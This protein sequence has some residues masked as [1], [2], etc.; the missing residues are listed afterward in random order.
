MKLNRKPSL[1]ESGFAPK[2]ALKKYFGYNNFRLEQEA[3]VEN[4]LN[5]NDTFVLMPTG[6]GKSICY[7]LPAL[8]IEGTAI[9]ISPLIALMKDQVDALKANGV[10]AAYLNSTQSAEE[11]SQILFRLRNGGLKILYLAPEKLLANNGE[12]ISFLKELSLSLVAIDEAHCISQWGH[13]FRPEYLMLYR[14][15]EELSDLPFI[16][17]TATADKLTRTDILDKL[18]LNKPQTYVSSFNRA[19]IEY[20]VKPKQNSFDKLL[21]FLAEQDEE[22]GIIYTLS[23]KET[24]SLA[25]RLNAE[26]YEA[27]PY[28]AGLGR[29]IREQNQD[30]FLKDEVKIIVATIAFGMGIDKSNVRYVVHMTMPKNIEG[31]YQ[32][33]GRAGRD[34]L[35]SKALMFYSN[36]DLFKLKSFAEVEGNEEQSAVMLK[37]LNTMGD[38]CETISCRRKYLL[39]YFG[40]P[41]KADNCNSC[42]V[43]LTGFEMID[44]TTPA[45]MVLS[46]MVRLNSGFGMN[47]I[48]Q[49][50]RGSKSEK[51]WESHKS[52]KTY[53]VGRDYSKDEW[54]YMIR[55]FIQQGCIKKSDGN[56]PVLE[57]TDT[58]KAVL[59]GGEKVLIRK[60]EEKVKEDN[61]T[62]E[63]EELPYEED[64]FTELRKVRK[65]LADQ[66]GVP[67]FVIFS[68]VTLIELCTYLPLAEKDLYHISGFGEVKIDKYGYSFLEEITAYCKIHKLDSRINLKVGT[69]KS[70]RPR[71]KKNRESDTKKASLELHKQGLS[72]K[73]I[74]RERG[75]AVTT[76]EGHLAFYVA[77]GEVGVNNFVIPNKRGRIEEVIGK[78][79]RKALTPIKNELGDDYSYGEIKMVIAHLEYLGSLN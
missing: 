71:K 42:D 38:Y 23:R 17:L 9:V 69:V 27:K 33:T 7:Q 74:S 55:E 19:N 60:P 62:L 13:D 72:I 18:K 8:M 32:E 59:T 48:I 30:L 67:P 39:N 26:G 44:A 11:Q 61:T 54:S 28:H 77:S 47:Y 5:G 4:V 21:D 24:E 34:G 66:Q 45:Q 50:L 75:L 57:F 70:N 10:D 43:C 76:I 22:A 78:V 53:G 46:A 29:E 14:L 79:G 25:A 58:S 31:Y 2:E 41:F 16:A 64:L 68:D 12:F 15:R 65:K 1:S 40:E 6:G 52:L 63:K 49:L 51:L 36:G 37:K 73:D 56:Y 3:I 35:P 20:H